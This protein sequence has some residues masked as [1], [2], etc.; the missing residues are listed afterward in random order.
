[1]YR[2][3][4]DV[5]GT[6]T[7]FAID[8]Y[9]NKKTFYYKIP[10][11]IQDQ[12][13]AIEKGIIYFINKFNIHPRDIIHLAHGTTVAT[14]IIIERK[15]TKTALITT[16]G[17][18]D[19]LEIGRQNRP[20]LYDYTIKKKLPLISRELR[21]EINERTLSNGKV[22]R[23][24]K[25]KELKK[26]LKSIKSKNVKSFSVCFLHSYKNPNNEKKIKDIL[27]KFNKDLYVSLSHEV[28]PEFREFERF[29]T[30]ILNSYIGP[31]MVNYSNNF[32]NKI[33]SLGITVNSYTIH[34]NG[35]LMAHQ[36]VQNY[37]VKTCLSGPAA[38][39]I[40]SMEVG[41]NAGY[42]NLITFDVGGT[43]TDVALIVNSSPIFTNERMVDGYPIKMPMI[44]IQVIGAGGG[45]IAEVDRYG[46]LKVGP[47][48]AGA[49]PGPVC[50]GLGGTQPTLT[51]ANMV[52]KRLSSKKLLADYVK[53]QNNSSLNSINKYI[54]KPLKI[55][56]ER[57]AYGIIKIA[58]ANMSRA[59]RSITTE[60]GLSL[61]KFSLF[62]YGGAGSLHASEVAVECGIK[63]VIVPPEPGTMCAKGMLLSDISRD[64][65]RT[66]VFLIDKNSWKNVNKIFD[67]IYGE[68]K[69]WLKSE[70]TKI[71]N[72]VVKTF[73]D[74]R[75]K[76]Q[77]HELKVE[78]EY[79]NNMKSFENFLKNFDKMQN[80]YYGYSV[81]NRKIEVVNFRVQ[82][83][84]KV[85]KIIN[86]IKKNKS[87]SK[88]YLKDARNIFFGYKNLGWKKTNI[89]IRA[90][91]PIKK[92]FKG[93]AIVEEMSSTTLILPNHNFT[94]DQFGN[95]IINII[96]G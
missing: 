83:S 25:L 9:L 52:L 73:I 79:G 2:I 19:I 37:P 16:K 82:I 63:K 27:N 12:S 13:I 58:I 72:C 59:I 51:D 77:N 17:F 96:D 24:V 1:M 88:K 15:G 11:T 54:S 61:N 22:E 84:K 66:D 41:K 45:S 57:A 8:D 5:G 93:P 44:D 36:E 81:S 26:I 74:A 62:A 65:V 89:Y 90:T 38:G 86:K 53:M 48:S 32:I 92:V 46:A 34:S 43:S 6:F 3:G 71:K 10:T 20:H 39:V 56:N 76:G 18:R 29:S 31:K 60:K 68:L 55:S 94:I 35:G 40:G 21:Y 7:D 47:K 67:S 95:L 75:Y 78:F 64:F 33:K 42:K 49:N 91:L 4:I 50:Y 87:T 85:D 69:E 23:N 14:N 28:L 30:T 80:L 70:N